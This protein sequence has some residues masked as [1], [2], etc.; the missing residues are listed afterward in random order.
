MSRSRYAEN[1]SR[2]AKLR[3]RVLQAYD[4]C[5]ICG[6]PVDGG[7]R[8]PHPLSAEVDE[9]VPVSKGGSPLDFRNLQLAHRCCNQWR[10]NR[11]M[12]YV[13]ELRA[14]ALARF[15]SFASPLSFVEALK[16]LEKQA[17]KAS[18]TSGKRLNFD[19]SAG[20]GPCR[21]SRSW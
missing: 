15:G 5:A 21:C 18:K 17:K 4:R 16:A 1:G 10:G 7:V 20:S 11:S 19:V 14:L 13:S 6:L 2:R 12:R 8:T 9:V 3:A